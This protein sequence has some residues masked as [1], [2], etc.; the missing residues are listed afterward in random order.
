[1][2]ET[3]CSIELFSNFYPD[4]KRVVTYKYFENTQNLHLKQAIMGYY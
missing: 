3:F 2:L 4:L 1:M